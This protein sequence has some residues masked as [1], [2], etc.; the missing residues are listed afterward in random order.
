[1]QQIPLIL[2]QMNFIVSMNFLLDT[3]LDPSIT[4]LR[5]DRQGG[6]ITH[7]SMNSLKE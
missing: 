1:M 6:P 7:L 2:P 3:R 4:H 5:R